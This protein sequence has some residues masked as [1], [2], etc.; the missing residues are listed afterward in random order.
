VFPSL[1]IV[2]IKIYER[3][4]RSESAFEIFSG[5]TEKEPRGFKKRIDSDG[6]G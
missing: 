1:R 4:K 6:F 5:E 2:L 3:D